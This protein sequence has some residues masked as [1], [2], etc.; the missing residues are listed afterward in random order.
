MRTVLGDD[1]TGVRLATLLQATL[2]GAPCL[3]YGDEIG[4]SGGL[5]PDCR[6]AFP[7]DEARWD[8]DLRAFVRGLLRLRAA[9]PVLRADAVV[10]VGAA[11]GAI[12]YERRVDGAGSDR[13]RQRRRRAGP[14]RPDPRRRARWHEAR[15]PRPAG[16][17]RDR[18]ARGRDGRRMAW[19]ASTSVRGVG[20]SS[21]WR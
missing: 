5:D 11:G 8:A 14:P 20:P 4:M 1:A 18:R 6:R 13:G 9:E 12:A 15:T 3:Y 16:R 2:P 7:W 19:R 17:R 10:V 21:A